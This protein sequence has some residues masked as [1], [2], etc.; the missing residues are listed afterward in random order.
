MAESTLSLEYDDIQLEIGRFVGFKVDPT[1]W[2]AAQIAEV[3]R[4]IQA[5]YR[6]FLYPP[7]IEGI[8]AGYE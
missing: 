1:T 3:D 7:A 8:E 4:Y 5:G 2:T 6:Q